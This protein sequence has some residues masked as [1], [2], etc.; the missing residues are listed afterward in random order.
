MKGVG[1]DDNKYLKLG[2][3]VIATGALVDWG[4]DIFSMNEERDVPRF[5]NA[6]GATSEITRY[7]FRLFHG[8]STAFFAV[9]VGRSYYSLF[10]NGPSPRQSDQSRRNKSKAEAHLV[11]KPAYIGLGGEF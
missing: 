7:P 8:A 1:L 10:K 4:K 3:T 11:L 6:I 2:A 5:Y 9:E